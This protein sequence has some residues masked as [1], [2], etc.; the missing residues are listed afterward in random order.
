MATSGS[1]KHLLGI[2]CEVAALLQSLHALNWSPPADLRPGAAETGRALFR[3]RTG[4][5]FGGAKAGCD[6]SW[7]NEICGKYGPSTGDSKR[8]CRE[9]LCGASKLQFKFI[10]VKPRRSASG[11]ASL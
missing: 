2:L 11:A 7:S 9:K 4:D 3:V 8:P 5:I 10:K 6:M 1:E